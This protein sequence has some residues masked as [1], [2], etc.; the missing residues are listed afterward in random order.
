MMMESVSLTMWWMLHSRTWT[1]SRSRTRVVRSTGPFTRSKGRAASSRARRMASASRSSR[2]PSSTSTSRGTCT[3]GMEALHGAAV[4][5]VIGGAQRL[6]ALDD[7]LDGALEQPRVQGALQAQDEGD[8]VGGQAREELLQAPGALLHVGEPQLAVAGQG[9]QLQGLLLGLLLL[10]CG[11]QQGLDAARRCR[12]RWGCRRG[13][14]GGG[15]PR[16]CRASG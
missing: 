10:R 11:L 4:D 13:P 9:R 2:V 1:S 5:G 3:R 8:V 14:P 12:R 15:G 7:L 16:R 6:V